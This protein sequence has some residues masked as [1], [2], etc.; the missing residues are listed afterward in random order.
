MR[1]RDLKLK[2]I[3]LKYELHDI[4]KE[5]RDREHKVWM[6]ISRI[7]PE[8]N[9]S[10][11]Y[12]QLDGWGEQWFDCSDCNGKG[13]VG[14]QTYNKII[15]KQKAYKAKQMKEILDRQEKRSKG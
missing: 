8:C 11:D 12:R 2:S 5:I 15:A 10:G 4:E 1:L 9:G 14:I 3:A 7:C 13:R 6:R